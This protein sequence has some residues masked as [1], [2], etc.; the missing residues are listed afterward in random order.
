MSVSPV[1]LLRYSFMD[2]PPAGSRRK[3]PKL[4]ERWSSI[5]RHH[6]AEDANTQT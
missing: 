3:Y 4:R 5:H 2:L 6:M 1:T